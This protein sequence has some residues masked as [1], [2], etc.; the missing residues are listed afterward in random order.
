MSY[1]AFDDHF[2]DHP[3]VAALSDGAFRLHVAGILYCSRH[4]TDG[5]VPADEAPRLV[6]RFRRQ[7]LVE[8]VER[9]IWRPVGTAG[10]AYEI[11]DYLDWNLTREQV[12]D[13]REKSRKRQARWAANK[14]SR[15]SD[16]P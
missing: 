14:W 5:L 13:R 7:A 11:H 1:A 9:G 12:L 2:A 3:K 10:D 8:L 15:P 16:D 4:L 6:R